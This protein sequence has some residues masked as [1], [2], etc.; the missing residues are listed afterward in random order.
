MAST[1]AMQVPLLD[2]KAQY[3]ALRNDILPVIERVLEGQQ[4]INGPEVRQLEVAAAA[5]C[6]CHAAIGVSSGT[7]ALLAAL[8]ALDIGPGD[9][10]IT[11][12]YTFFA[13]AGCIW[14]VGARPVFVDINP[15]TYNLDVALLERALSPRTK[16]IMPVHLFGQMT[17][18]R[19]VMDFAQRHRLHVIEDAAQAIGAT[20]NGRPAGSIGHVGCYSFFPSKNLGGAGDGGLI[21]T[22]DPALADRLLQCR[23]HG[24]QKKYFHEHVGGNFR[25]DTL[26]A[27]YLLIK[28]PH[29]ERW[30]EARRKNARRYDQLLADVPEVVTPTVAPGNQ[31]IF[32]QYVIRTP[33][34]DEL[35]AHLQ[36]HGV[37]T[38]IY[39]PLP[40][41]LQKCFAPMGHREGDFP[42]SERASRE[43]LAI[44][45]Y[46]ELT[47]EQLV[48]VAQQIKAF[49]ARR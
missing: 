22:Q 45:I 15:Q 10:V 13:T 23:N 34:R 8:M 20:Q 5:Y 25:L 44:P 24:A 37:G 18:M 14:R 48:Y 32:N 41:H 28:L 9:E 29:L 30:H 49:F 38:A 26:Q 33:R 7:D 17:P 11:S 12:P 43:T 42:H 3:L 39:Y 35:Q 6:K 4:L 21:T 27:A 16:A 46:P 36:D 2:L 31:S 40:L 47:D 19:E 1:T